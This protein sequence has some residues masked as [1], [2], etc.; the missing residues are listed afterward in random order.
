MCGRYVSQ[1]FYDSVDSKWVKKFKALH[2]TED[3]IKNAIYGSM[4]ELTKDRKYYY[5]GYRPH[6]TEEGLKVIGEIVNLYGEKIVEAIRAD[7]ETR[8]KQILLKGLKGEVDS[9]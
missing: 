2:M 3:D 1:G 7:D 4:R 9:K 8:S 5:N 6:W